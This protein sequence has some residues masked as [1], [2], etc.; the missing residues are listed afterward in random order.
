MVLPHH[1]PPVLGRDLSEA[2]LIL[3]AL[4]FECLGSEFTVGPEITAQG[5]RETSRISTPLA[6][7]PSLLSSPLP[8]N[9]QKMRCLNYSTFLVNLCLISLLSSCSV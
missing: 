8:L 7:E 4:F 1:A 2:W 3:T 9:I 5:H 6:T